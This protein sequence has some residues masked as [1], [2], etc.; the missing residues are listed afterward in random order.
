MTL[1]S[2]TV[3]LAVALSLFGVSAASSAEPVSDS[4][5]HAISLLGPTTVGRVSMDYLGYDEATDSVWVPGGN[6]GK[7]FV[8]NARTEQIRSAANFPV[9]ESDGRTLGPSSV[10]FGP[11][12]AYVGNRA[13]ATV[14]ALNISSLERGSC[15]TLASTPDG[16]AYVAT[17]GEVWVTTPRTQSITL[18]GVADGGVTERG[19]IEVDG[20]PEGYAVDSKRGRFFTNLEDKDQTLAIDVAT[21][22]VKARWK[23]GCGARGPR[24]LAL[25]SERGLL[26]VACTSGFVALALDRDGAQVGTIATGDGVDNPAIVVGMKRLFA[27]A[28]AVGTLSVFDYRENGSMHLLNKVNTAIGVRVVVADKLGKAFAADS[29]GGRIWVVGP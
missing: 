29:A 15:T 8:I 13:D 17:A 12:S 28:G 5:A 18:L 10:T 19:R 24:G 25:D 11:H 2:G 16:L 3:G 20:T 4:K 21:H 9:R 6:T 22:A 7:V 27:A 1:C 23:T 26:F 14:C